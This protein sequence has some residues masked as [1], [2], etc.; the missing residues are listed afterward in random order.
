[1]SKVSNECKF[2]SYKIDKCSKIY[3]IKYEDLSL[4]PFFNGM[5]KS[6]E[7]NSLNTNN[8]IVLKSE[9]VISDCYDNKEILINTEEH[10]NFLEKYINIW[11]GKINEEDYFKNDSVYS[12]AQDQI[13]NADDI[14]LIR[15]W[16]CSKINLLN[17]KEKKQ[18]HES[19]MYKNYYQI[20]CFNSLLINMG[21]FLGMKGLISKICVFITTILWSCSF[22]ELE[23]V[24]KYK[25]FKFKV[26]NLQNTKVEKKIEISDSTPNKTNDII[27]GINDNNNILLDEKNIILD[28]NINIDNIIGKN[29][30]ID[31]DYNN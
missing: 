19:R 2:F 31:I 28:N 8:S 26:N 5:F 27:D 6:N 21:E 23:D 22:N 1:M 9:V 30:I 17:E 24:K 29:D 3:K 12:G 7:Y 20:S 4:V 16:V 18:Y 11:S 15:E 25:L 14:K 10:H 13:I